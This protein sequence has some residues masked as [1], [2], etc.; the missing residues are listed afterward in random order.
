MFKMS[1]AVVT[2]FIPW[3]TTIINAVLVFY[4]SSGEYRLK[5]LLDQQFL[6]HAGN[7]ENASDAITASIKSK[8]N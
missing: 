3:G 5:Y 4:R 2:I 1:Y 6:T 7:G 8:P